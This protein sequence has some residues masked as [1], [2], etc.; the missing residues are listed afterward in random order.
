MNV[1][2]EALKRTVMTWSGDL[3]P[4]L[5]IESPLFVTRKRQ[6]AERKIVCISILS[7]LQAG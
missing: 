2:I 7:R 6:F 4:M 3:I 5:D 1:G